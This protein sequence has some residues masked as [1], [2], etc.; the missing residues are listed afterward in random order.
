MHNEILV[1]LKLCQDAYPDIF[2]AIQYF[3]QIDTIHTNDQI[4]LTCAEHAYIRAHNELPKWAT[5]IESFDTIDG[6]L[7]VVYRDLL[8]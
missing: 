3:K 2:Q 6:D 4:D 5:M 1:Y 8:S 7:I